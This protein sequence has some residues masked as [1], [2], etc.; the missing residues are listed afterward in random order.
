M[1]HRARVLPAPGGFRSPDRAQRNPGKPPESNKGNGIRFGFHFAL[2]KAPG[3]AALY[4]GY[5]TL[6]R[7]RAMRFGLANGA[8]VGRWAK[9]SSAMSKAQPV[10]N[11]LL[12]EVPPQFIALCH[13][14]GVSPQATLRGLAAMLCGLRYDEDNRL[15]PLDAPLSR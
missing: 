6:T 4:P 8:H 10:S 13:T 9:R 2:L 11:V 14:S 7:L 15:L 12:V 1:L 3:F 5:Q